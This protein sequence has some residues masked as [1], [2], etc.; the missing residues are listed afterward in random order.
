M[1][2]PTAPRR[3]PLGV[4]ISAAGATAL[5]L[6]VSGRYGFHRDETYFVMAGRDLDWGY[7]DQPPLTPLVARVSE[8]LFGP[9]PTALRVLP[10]LAVGGVAILAA[11][12]ARRFGGGRVAQVFAAFAGGWTGVLLGEGHLLSTAVFDYFFWALGLWIVVRLLDGDDARWWL[13]LGVVVGAGLQ[14]KHTM[15]FFAAAILVGLLA[16]RQR[17]LLASPY[18][19]LGAAIAALIALPNLIWQANHGWPQLEVAEAL[20]AR[21]DGPLAFV[22]QQPA[23]LSLTLA[24]PAFAGL[25]WL[26]RSEVS[27]RWRPLPIAYLVLVTG[28][29]VTGG[30]SYYV[31]PMYS[32]LLAAGGVWFESLSV[33]WRRL[34]GGLTVLGVAVGLFIALPLLPIERVGSFDP[35]G[36]LGETVG[37]PE[38]IDQIAVAHEMIPTGQRERAVVF[39]GSYGEAGAVD[40]LGPEAGLPAAAS[41]HNNYWLWGPPPQHGPI[42]GVGSVAADLELICPDLARVATL[43][44]PYG[45]ENEV[46]GQPLFLCLEPGG[47]LSDIWESL[48]HYN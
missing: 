19:W 16:T 7:V 13:A 47:Q 4:W 1:A 17:R 22:I 35:T 41:G 30:K 48:R 6:A 21:S 31:A 24:I 40:V 27:R 37:W 26:A 14:N 10:A 20:R 33:S 45:V 42:I 23:L 46:A 3:L 32:A 38:L 12:M 25:W 36:E 15:A 18:P 43:D 11:A 2:Q 44:N 29:L 28:F 5:L 9:S 39:T 8:T 34:V